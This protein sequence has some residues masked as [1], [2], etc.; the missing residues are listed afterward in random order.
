MPQQPPAKCLYYSDLPGTIA[1]STMLGCRLPV[2]QQCPT[3]SQSM[4]PDQSSKGRRSM[5]PDQEPKKAT[6]E[7]GGELTYWKNT[8][9][10]KLFKLE[11]NNGPRRV[12]RNGYKFVDHHDRVAVRR[13]RQRDRRVPA[14][15]AALGQEPHLEKDAH[16]ALLREDRQALPREV[17]REEEARLVPLGSDRPP[18][19]AIAPCPRRMFS[20]MF[21]GRALACRSSRAGEK[22]MNP[23]VSPP[24]RG[25]APSVI[26]S[27]RP[28][29]GNSSSRDA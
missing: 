17:D 26:E 24:D 11:Q 10:S 18:R 1:L 7:R 2:M 21:G 22:R 6:P 12:M 4:L 20:T 19:L 9:P 14:E 8:M 25:C 15:R 16:L 28:V 3:H 27:D 5:L 13:G 23:W 29:P